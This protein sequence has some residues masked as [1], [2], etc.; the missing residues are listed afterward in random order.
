MIVCELTVGFNTPDRENPEMA[1]AEIDVFAHNPAA[2]A[3]G[4]DGQYRLSIRR[5]LSMNRWEMFRAYRHTS[6]GLDA[7]SEVIEKVGTLSE[8]LIAARDAWA[9]AWGDDPHR[10]DTACDHTLGSPGRARNCA[11]GGD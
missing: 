10:A 1:F 11:Q 2:R 8:V 3:R 5:N 9:A 6:E 4:E 7:E